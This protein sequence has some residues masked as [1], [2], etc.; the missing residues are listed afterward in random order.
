MSP[1]NASIYVAIIGND[2][3]VIVSITIAV[4]DKCATLPHQHPFA[5]PSPLPLCPS[6]ASDAFHNRSCSGFHYFHNVNLSL[7]PPLV[8]SPMTITWCRIAGV[9]HTC[10]CRQYAMRTYTSRQSA[11]ADLCR[12]SSPY[13]ERYR[14][15]RD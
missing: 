10:G 9:I 1:K 6:L 13:S 3:S 2:L 8:L 12:R 14:F 4:A 11:I 15:A 5:C 7:P